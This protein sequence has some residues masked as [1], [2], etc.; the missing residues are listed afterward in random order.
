MSQGDDDEPVILVCGLVSASGQLLLADSLVG[1]C[2][3]C[4]RRV[5]Y[6]PHAPRPHVLR[7][8]ECTADNLGPDDVIDVPDRMLDDAI[9]FFRKKAH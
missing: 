1:R 8:M 6:R 7:C 4:E 9:A 2:H 5:E 3:I